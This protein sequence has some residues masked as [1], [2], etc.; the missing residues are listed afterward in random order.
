MSTYTRRIKRQSL[1]NIQNMESNYQ[2][3]EPLDG[4]NKEAVLDG[5]NGTSTH[6]FTGK[7]ENNPDKDDNDENLSWHTS[8]T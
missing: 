3:K 5:P 4:L 7:Q 8:E 2:Q 1:N 6:A